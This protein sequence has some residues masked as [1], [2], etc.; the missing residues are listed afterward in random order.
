MIIEVI[1]RPP[2]S[3][4]DV[5]ISQLSGLLD[6]IRKDNKSCYLPGDYYINLFN[7]DEHQPTAEFVESLFSQEFVPLLN[8]P[9]STATLID[10]IICNDIP[11]EIS[12]TGIFYC[13]ITD[14]YPVFHIERSQMNDQMRLI[15]KRGIIVKKKQNEIY[16][17]YQQVGLD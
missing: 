7:V 1:Y 5:F 6:T 8:K 2:N 13:N 14:H 12:L 15:S 9:T 4:I 11:S 16:W 10:N 17:L 3:D